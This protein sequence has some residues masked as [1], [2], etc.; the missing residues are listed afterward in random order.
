[1]KP[2]GTGACVGGTRFPALLPGHSRRD[3]N[4]TSQAAISQTR[5]V[6]Q[7]DRRGQNT[8]AILRQ[9]AG[10]AAAENQTLYPPP[11]ARR[12][13]RALTRPGEFDIFLVLTR[14]RA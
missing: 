11:S 13:C 6:T 14:M 1:M 7:L 8:C 4:M 3:T 10:H 5:F 2:L 12:W 9:R